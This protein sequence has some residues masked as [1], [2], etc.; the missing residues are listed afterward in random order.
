LSLPLI[1]YPPH[2]PLISIPM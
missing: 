1:Y 2:E